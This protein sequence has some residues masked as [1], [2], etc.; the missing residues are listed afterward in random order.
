MQ[1]ALED[2]GYDVVVADD[3]DAALALLDSRGATVAGLVTDIN[4]GRKSDGWTVA[5][6]ARE[7]KDD[8]PVV[9]MTGGAAAEWAVRGVPRSVLVT[10][11]FATGEIV[12][13]LSTLLDVGDT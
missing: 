11:P 13:A 10:K 2:A 6:H 9:Y 8:L 12:T 7:I 4:M 3:G 1:H 5:R